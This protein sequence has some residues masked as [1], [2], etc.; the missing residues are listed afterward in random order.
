MPQVA[1]FAAATELSVSGGYFD[2]LDYLAAH[3]VAH[4]DHA[5]IAAA[6]RAPARMLCGET[7]L[8]ELVGVLEEKGYGWIREEVEA[9]A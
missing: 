9:A 5:A 2:L 3:E 7:T 1:A 6:M 4:R 8:P